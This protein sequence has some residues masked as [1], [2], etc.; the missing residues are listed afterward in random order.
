MI[1]SSPHETTEVARPHS[2]T[3]ALHAVLIAVYCGVG[4][5]LL[6]AA[7]LLERPEADI[8]GL[9]PALAMRAAVY[10]TVVV[11][12]FRMAAGSSWARWTLVAGLGTAGLLS[13][14]AEPVR[15]V[16]TA[17]HFGELMVGWTTESVVIGALR[18]VHILAVLIALPALVRAGR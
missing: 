1:E 6:R 15:A 7:M 2:V 4:E 10:L 17:P 9:L 13:L 18:A 3:V 11:L 16:L 8:D 14:L 12:T 5:T